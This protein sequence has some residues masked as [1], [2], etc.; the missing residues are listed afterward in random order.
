M[1]TMAPPRFRL[2]SDCHPDAVSWATSIWKMPLRESAQAT[3]S[4]F[5]PATMLGSMAW[6]GLL[7][8][9]PPEAEPANSVQRPCSVTPVGSV[10][11]VPGGASGPWLEAATGGGELGSGS[12]AR[13]L[14]M[15]DPEP[16]AM[17]VS[18]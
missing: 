4:P 18:P 7:L 3:N 12:L 2:P 13:L 14:S 15:I 1:A 16:P 8:R 9:P 5:E 11:V 10:E 17:I 6:P